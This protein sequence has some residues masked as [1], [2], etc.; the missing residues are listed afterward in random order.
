VSEHEPREPEP[1]ERPGDDDVEREEPE[2]APR[3]GA[4]NPWPKTSSGDIEDPSAD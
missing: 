3:E 1:D 2:R 4:G